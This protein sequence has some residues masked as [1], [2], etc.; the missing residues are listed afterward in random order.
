MKRLV[1]LLAFAVLAAPG[2]FAQE[3]YNNVQIGAFGDYVRLSQTS[4]DLA[5][6]GGRVGF[7]IYRELKIEAEM[8]YDFNRV[9][10]ESFN[11]PG[12]GLVGVTNS[13]IRMIHGEFGPKLDLGHSRVHAFVTL[14]SGFANFQLS[15]RP[16]SLAGFTSSVENL[17]TGDVSGVVYPGGG[18]EGHLGPVGLRLDVGDELYLNGGAHNNIRVSFGPYFQF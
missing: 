6:L 14:K 1:V 5:G 2:V 4:S 8:S 18:I 12:T 16:P 9:F 7:K 11:E 3:N 10:T 13:N 17:R 15:N